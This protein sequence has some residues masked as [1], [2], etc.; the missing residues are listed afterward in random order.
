[1]RRETRA[2]L[3]LEAVLAFGT[4]VILIIGFFNLAMGRF[5]LAYDIGSAGEARMV[6][7]LLAEAIN[8]AYANGENFT[9]YLTNGTIDF[10]KLAN[11]TSATGLAVSLP[12]TISRNSRE[13]RISKSASKTFGSAWNTSI[14]VIPANIT[15]LDNT[16]LF[17]EITIRN[18][19]SYILIYA[20]SSRINVVN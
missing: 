20:S 2:Q 7:E 5:E 18:N 15:R 10:A 3:S 12:I 8:T 6:G 16:S 14:P 11:Q 4:A 9:I 13:I 1:M 19:G 17:P